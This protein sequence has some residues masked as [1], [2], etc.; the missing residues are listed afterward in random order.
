M[1][2]V[3]PATD[4]RIVNSGNEAS[5]RLSMATPPHTATPIITAISIPMAD[6][7]AHW[8]NPLSLNT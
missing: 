5:R 8:L 4:K 6:N 7:R 3:K 2:I 1:A